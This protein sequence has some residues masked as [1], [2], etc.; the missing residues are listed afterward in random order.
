MKNNFKL[1]RKMDTEEFKNLFYKG[2]E[3]KQGAGFCP[4]KCFTESLVYASR[5]SSKITTNNL[6][7]TEITCSFNFGKRINLL[8]TYLP[9]EPYISD[10]SYNS[11]EKY[12]DKSI[13]Y[14]AHGKGLPLSNYEIDSK[15]I[16]QLNNS[17]IKIK[18][19]EEIDYDHTMMSEYGPTIFHN[20]PTTSLLNYDEYFIQLPIDFSILAL[21]YK[22]IPKGGLNNYIKNRVL[23][24]DWYILEEL[25]KGVFPVT[26]AIKLNK[27]YFNSIDN[28]SNKIIVFSSPNLY[29]LNAVIE[30]VRMI[31]Y[32]PNRSKYGYINERFNNE[33]LMKY[34]MESKE[35]I[36]YNYEG[37]NFLAVTN[38]SDNKQVNI[39]RKVK[40][41]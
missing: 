12:N 4:K 33:H 31:S 11:Y 30:D 7:L 37:D 40:K 32:I 2:F 17:I 3:I 20:N 26:L 36:F 29:K 16:N 10:K 28:L 18:K 27:R 38:H 41:L 14:P 24:K 23:G 13:R 19:I 15:D 9:R 8:T 21:K 39:R 6:L 35:N 1:Y 5:L 34:S 22:A 25:N